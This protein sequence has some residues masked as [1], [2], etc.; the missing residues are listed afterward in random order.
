MMPDEKTERA[1]SSAGGERALSLVFHDI[2]REVELIGA[3][4][5]TLRVTIYLI[6]CQCRRGDREE[7][8]REKLN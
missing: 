1:W 7:K 8:S 3:S 5:N 6:T 4:P 2:G